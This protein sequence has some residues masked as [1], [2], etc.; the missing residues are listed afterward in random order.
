[1]KA[2]LPLFMSLFLLGCQPKIPDV[3]IS[4]GPD[5]SIDEL[6]HVTIVW[7]TNVPANSRVLYSQDQKTWRDTVL[8]EE[9]QLHE[10]PLNYLS[11]DTLWYYRVSSASEFYSGKVSSAIYEFRT[12]QNYQK[13][14]SFEDYLSRGWSAL[15]G[16]DYWSAYDA[17]FAAAAL[18]KYSDD[19]L[20]GL[21]WSGLLLDLY[22]ADAYDALDQALAINRNNYDALAG[23]ALYFL[24]SENYDGCLDD[25]NRLFKADSA[26]GSTVI[27]DIIYPERLR[28]ILALACYNK[29]LFDLAQQHCDR[30]DADNGLLSNDPG[31]WVVGAASYGTYESA[32]LA[33]IRSYLQKYGLI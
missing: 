30:I 33:L 23:R 9:R 27:P 13:L 32:L 19:A 8:A 31:T 15:N 22:P 17:F 10:V 18:R 26:Y 28:T 12:P 3:R 4:S 11:A 7:E 6:A 29:G 16:S 20:C 5:V 14:F 1:M 21:G 24:Q 25:L 2:Y